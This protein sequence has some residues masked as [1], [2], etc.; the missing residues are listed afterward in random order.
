MDKVIH[1][2]LFVGLWANIRTVNAQN[3]ACLPGTSS[4]AIESANVRAG[5]MN[6]GDMFWNTATSL[7][8]F[9]WPKTQSNTQTIKNLMFASALWF[10]GIDKSDGNKVIASVQ[11]Y[12]ESGRFRNFW[13]GPVLDGQNPATS[14]LNCKV[15][16]QHFKVD[17][18]SIDSFFTALQTNPLPLA[19]NKIPA[20]IKYWPGKGNQF[21]KAS[22]IDSGLVN[23]I[24]FDQKLAVFIDV[25][26]NGIYD[27]QNGDYPNLENRSSMVWWVMNDIGNI[28]SFPENTTLVP[29]ANLEYQVLAS[30][31]PALNQQNYLDN[32]IFF[33]YIILNKGFRTLDSS[34]I[35][36]W[37]DFDIGNPEDDYV[38]CHVMK[39]LSIGFNADNDDEG[40]IGYGL[41]PPAIAFK[42]LD[43]PLAYIS[44]GIDNNRNGIVDE[45]G[46]KILMSNFKY[47]NIGNNPTNG[48]TRSFNDFYNYLKGNWKNGSR[49]TFGQEGITPVGTSNPI[50]QFMFPGL[51]DPIGYG[52]GGTPQNPITLP[53]WSESVAGNPPG[54]R[55]SLISAGPFQ[56]LPG[57]QIKYSFVTLV[58]FG[59]NNLENVNQIS[60]ISDSL[61]LF[62]PVLTSTNPF[63]KKAELIFNLYPNPARE[64]ILVSTNESIEGLSLY[65]M[66]GM[67]MFYKAV[68][69][70]N[71]EI[72]TN[73]LPRGMYWVKASLK[74]GTMIKKL[75]LE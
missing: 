31:Y 30:T 19:E 23:T 1:V 21:L 37:G 36:L 73:E 68:K 14:S 33:E 38:Q 62:L 43:G 39:N 72:L 41:N 74:S 61:D 69:S 47:Y 17:R 20:Q 67:Q 40:V 32:S 34:Y 24:A 46:E 56:L 63:E 13:P 18:I 45:S 71:V 48:E 55:R 15:W 7:P 5:L 58:G 2:F 22:A 35:G 50:C 4:I 11:T 51:S 28:K 10:G 16:D 9:N 27:P 59:G 52:L 64:K 12:R 70:Q 49:T 75:I 6:Q 44:D 42:V 53:E 26:F 54:D 66:Q 65:N 60:K 8:N 29:G 57:G 3:P 25:N